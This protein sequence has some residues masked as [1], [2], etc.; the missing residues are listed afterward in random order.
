MKKIL[1]IVLA[2]VMILSLSTVVF[3]AQDTNAT[4][5]KEYVV[6]NGEAPAETFEFEVEFVDFKNNEGL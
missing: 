1:S 2:L 4:F 5:T 3:A 6:N